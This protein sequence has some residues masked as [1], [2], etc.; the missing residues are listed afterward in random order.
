MFRY[1]DSSR[2]N[3]SV[4]SI[5][6]GAAATVARRL[7]RRRRGKKI[8]SIFPFSGSLILTTVAT[9]AAAATVARELT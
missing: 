9:A 5:V 2:T 8:Q 3:M 4:R 7:H 1:Y 6:R